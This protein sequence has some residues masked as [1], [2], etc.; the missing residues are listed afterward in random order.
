MKAE[1]VTSTCRF[2]KHWDGLYC[3][4]SVDD[5]SPMFATDKDLG[6]VKIVTIGSFGCNRWEGK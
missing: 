2:C 3:G 1:P 4:M 6:L 5:S